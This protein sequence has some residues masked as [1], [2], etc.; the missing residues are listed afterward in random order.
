MKIQLP[1]PLT[2]APPPRSF[3]QD[4]RLLTTT[5][6]RLTWNKLR[7]WPAKIWILIIISSL[8][9]LGM[10]TGLGFLA[11]GAFAQ[12]SPD[13]AQG[14]LSL[15][16]MIGI[17][18]EMF[19]GIT[20]AFA[21]LYMSEDLE[22]LFVAPISTRAVFAAK[23]LVIAFSNLL[24]AVVFIVLPGL[25][26]GL[27]FK[28]S[29]AYF[30]WLP[31]IALAL[32]AIGTA[33]A[34]LLN[35][36]VMR[37]VPPHR[38]KEAVG[39]IGAASGILIALVFQIPN[40]IMSNP[41]N[42]NLGN[43]LAAQEQLLHVMNYF[44]WGW[45]A[46]A[47]ID[48]ATGRYLPALGRTLLILALGAGIF[49]LALLLVE[50]G[51]R[52]GWISLS[53]G[54]GRRRKSRLAQQK[55]TQP[56]KL[57]EIPVLTQ[58]QPWPL[59][60][61]WHGMW[62]VAKKDLLYMKRDTREWFGYLTPL[63]LMCFFTARVLFFPGP[64]AEQTLVM[65]LFMYTIM[66]SGNMALQSF[67]REGESEWLLNSVP[68]AG[69]PVVMGKL[70]ASVLPTLILMEALLT[71]TGLAIGL[72]ANILTAMAVGAVLIS[73]GSSSIGLYYSVNN[74]RYNPDT[75]QQRIA[76][77]AALVMYLVNLLFIGLLA[78]CLLYAFP[79]QG[80]LAFVQG[81]QPVPFAW[82][83]PQTLLYLLYLPLV[84]LQWLP[85]VRIG[86]GLLITGALWLAVFLGFMRATVRQS[87]KGFRVELVTNTGKKKR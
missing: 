80:L 34:E 9:F 10:L 1:P 62:A 46:Q 50:R 67:G 13:T 54:G 18:A 43:W 24:A 16:F 8:G 76:P 85:P 53:Q 4:L 82:G 21:T 3:W 59:A 81:L 83:F 58:T 65:V 35:M 19:F 56:R 41:E 75:P 6:L 77:G 73:V 55:Q 2:Q 33:L 47:L 84:P 63:L 69:W 38:S 30:L 42:I 61:P 64:G 71:G 29:V 15:L 79:P 39:V 27:L 72:P 66:F 45:S 74:S 25:F 22:L 31:V 17:A 32:L 51:F 87:L 7:H 57:R 12:L 60:S 26:Y 44:P 49:S 28:A 5:Q 70:I 36:V 23:T 40:I 37:I 52:R 14:F 68:L 11:F 20:A 78:F 48:V 86:F